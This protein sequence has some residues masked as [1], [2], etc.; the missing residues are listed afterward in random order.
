MRVK[1]LFTNSFL[2]R[3]PT[4]MFFLAPTKITFSNYYWMETATSTYTG[5]NLYKEDNMFFLAPP[6]H[7]CSLY[8]NTFI[9]ICRKI[10]ITMHTNFVLIC[11]WICLCTLVP[12]IVSVLDI[13]EITQN[14]LSFC[15]LYFDDDPCTSSLSTESTPIHSSHTSFYTYLSLNPLHVHMPNGPFP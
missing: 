3:A 4:L 6:Y 13:L 7:T 5:S 9:T 15:N 1:H 10:D 11:F 14:P 2:R 12:L 8:L